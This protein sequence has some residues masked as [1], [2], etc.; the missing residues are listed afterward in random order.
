[1]AKLSDSCLLIYQNAVV[2]HPSLI[3]ARLITIKMPCLGVIVVFVLLLAALFLVWPLYFNQVLY[4]GYRNGE[5][6]PITDQILPCL[7]K[8]ALQW[9][10]YGDICLDVSPLV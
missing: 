2:Y 8:Q 6:Y 4:G 7:E 10:N 9:G 5:H 3:L 1:M